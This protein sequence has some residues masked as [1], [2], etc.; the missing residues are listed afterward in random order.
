MKPIVFI[1]DEIHE[2]GI[3]KLK[4]NGFKINKSLVLDN[5]EL[6]KEIIRTKSKVLIIRSTRTIDS[7]FI[8]SV[9]DSN[10]KVICTASSGF[11]N[12]DLLAAKKLKIKVLNVPNGNFISA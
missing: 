6:S 10:L 3:K 8:S 11:D 9:T 4:K 1:A 2:I 12:I 7:G 5:N